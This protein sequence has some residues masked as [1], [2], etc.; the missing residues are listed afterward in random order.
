MAERY[1]STGRTRDTGFQVGVRRT[2]AVSP[3]RAWKVL[4]SPEGTSLWLGPGAPSAFVVGSPF[5]LLDGS[6][7]EPR[8][9]K[10]SHLRLAWQPVGWDRPSLVQLRVIPKGERSVIAFHQE[11]LPGPRERARRKSY[12]SGALEALEDLF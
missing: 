9:V 1:P 11:H 6:K 5:E 2:F 10:A 8:V 7:V 3:T 4:L 12:Y